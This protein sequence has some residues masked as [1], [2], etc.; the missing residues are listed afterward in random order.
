MHINLSNENPF[1]GS[2]HSDLR[3]EGQKRWPR[4]TAPW[5]Q[6]WSPANNHT[7]ILP[8]TPAVTSSEA[9]SPS[10]SSEVFTGPAPFGRPGSRSR[11]RR[12]A[13]AP[14]VFARASNAK[15][16]LSKPAPPRKGVRR[17]PGSKSRGARGPRGPSPGRARRRG[18]LP[19]PARA[20]HKRRAGHFSPRGPGH[21]AAQGEPASPAALGAAG[22][23][24][25]SDPAPARASQ[26][27]PPGAARRRRRRRHFLPLA[28]ASFPLSGY[29]IHLG[30]EPPAPHRAAPRPLPPAPAETAQRPARP[31][32]ALG[33]R[34]RR[35]AA[36]RIPPAS[37]HRSEPR[38]LLAPRPHESRPVIGRR[39]E[40]K[41]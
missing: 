10:W 3:G 30:P 13:C 37:R 40:V 12:P 27:R 39:A 31:P 34:R 41:G 6:P 4:P 19:A 38:R 17:G 23:P 29:S 5:G 25:P 2:R 7:T 16:D 8:R 14:P 15:Q 1:A 24:E 26:P 33:P 9:L 35:T 36:W 32:P 11:G 21:K 18:L 28:V 20:A 22:L